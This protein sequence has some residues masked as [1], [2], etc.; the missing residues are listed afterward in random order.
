MEIQ[1]ANSNARSLCANVPPYLPDLEIIPIAFVV[2]IHFLGV[3]TKLFSPACFLNPSHSTGLKSGLFNCSQKPNNSTVFL[4]RSQ[5]L[6][7][8]SV[9]SE[10]LCLAISVNEI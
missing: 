9:F 10:V 8:S 6:I 1:E 3:N 4:F 2:S 5:F 7:T